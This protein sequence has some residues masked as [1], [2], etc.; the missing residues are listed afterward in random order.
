[1]HSR[2]TQ[3]CMAVHASRPAT[4]QISSAM[5]LGSSR[6]LPE[7]SLS[8]SPANRHGSRL[9]SSASVGTSRRAVSCN[10]KRD[11][12][13]LKV[14]S[15]GLTGRGIGASGCTVPFSMGSVHTQPTSFLE[16][17]VQKSSLPNTAVRE[18]VRP[19][20]RLP[21]TG[22]DGHC[23]AAKSE[24]KSFLVPPPLPK[25]QGKLVVVLDLDETLV[26]S[27][28]GPI[29]LRPG[30][31]R[32][33]NVLRGRCEVVVWTAGE[34]LYALNVIRV[35]D[36]SGCIQHCIYRSKK[37]WTNKPGCVKDLTGL[38]R[39]L[40]RVILIDNISDCLRANPRNGLLVTD[41]RG[42]NVEGKDAD[43]TL[44]VIADVIED[45]LR[46]PNISIEAFHAHPQLRRRLIKCDVGGMVEVLTL[47]QDR[48]EKFMRSMFAVPCNGRRAVLH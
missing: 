36:P 28:D 35:I 12:L 34:R 13:K 25:D 5:H 41:F 29:I 39:P 22:A 26:Y 23:A 46:E 19:F 20:V 42:S 30:A 2:G 43:T 8:T 11:F 47:K 21:P 37:W 18:T 16:T 32:L 7:R 9:S 3:G 31:Q 10:R 27:R 44:F 24:N 1:M 33:L 17:R 15:S 4:R 6:I 48:Y 45:V 38:G 40:D 14:G